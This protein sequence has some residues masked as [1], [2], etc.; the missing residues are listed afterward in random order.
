MRKYRLSAGA[1]ALATGLWLLSAASAAPPALS[2][3]SYKKAITA[4]VAYL[5]DA[6]K[7]GA[8]AK[9]A[10]RTVKAV[11][12]YLASYGEAT[13]DAALTADAL[14]VAEAMAKKDFKGAEEAAKGLSSPKGGAKPKGP[15]HT[16]AKFELDDVMSPYR[17]SKTGGLNMEADI[18]AAI[19]AGGTIDPKTAELIGIRTG[20]IADFTLHMPNEKATVKPDNKAKWEKLSKE[21]GDLGK[22]LAEEAGKPK[23]DMKA[24][25]GILKKLDANCSNCHEPFRDN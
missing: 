17:P 2:K 8:P 3:D 15:I 23:A 24:I 14:K 19:K 12:M 18:R 16:L 13:G 10:I 6:L 9:G 21:M 11:A 5:Q 20:V 4:D 22:Q 25:T 1:L 7:G